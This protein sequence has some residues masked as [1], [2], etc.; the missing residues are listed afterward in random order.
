MRSR[1]AVRVSLSLGL[2]RDGLGAALQENGQPPAVGSL[3]NALVTRISAA[4]RALVDGFQ[5]DFQGIG[6]EAQLVQSERSLANALLALLTQEGMQAV[7]ARL[8]HLAG[9]AEAEGLPFRVLIDARRKRLEQL[10]WE[11]L[12]AATLSG[13]GHAGMQVLRLWRTSGLPPAAEGPDLLMEVHALEATQGSDPTVAG[14]DAETLQRHSHPQAQRRHNSLRALSEALQ[15]TLPSPGTRLSLERQLPLSCRH[16][17]HRL[18]TRMEAT[19]FDWH[20]PVASDAMA[21]GEADGAGDD[22][23]PA[24]TVGP[25][26][27][28]SGSRLEV[29]EVVAESP[30]EGRALA[31]G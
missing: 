8:N 14:P 12:E 20:E 23:L 11:L 5:A 4:F 16:I 6:D 3:D 19:S 10:P 1:H 13:T 18:L 26:S 29:L 31:P 27:P 28:A 17:H 24:E 2:W 9:R 21:E 15:E 22:G 25:R 30:G 7:G